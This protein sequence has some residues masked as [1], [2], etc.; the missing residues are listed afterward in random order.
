MIANPR[1]RM[2]GL[3]DYGRDSMTSPLVECAFGVDVRRWH[4]HKLLIPDTTFCCMWRTDDRRLA[5]LKVRVESDTKVRLIYRVRMP[6]KRWQHLETPVTVAWDSCTYGGRRPWI[7]CPHCARSVAV[8]YF[9]GARP[10]TFSCRPCAGLKYAS[11]FNGARLRL[12]RKAEKIRQ[13][14]GGSGSLQESFP[15]KPP[16]MQW[17]RYE[18]LKAMAIKAEQEWW[19]RSEFL[20]RSL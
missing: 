5:S 9:G 10:C 14:L 8:L 18:R 4:R 16:T 3:N 7:L 13:Q 1:G 11:Q 2:P 15:D 12:M 20:T 17:R 6:G 19:R